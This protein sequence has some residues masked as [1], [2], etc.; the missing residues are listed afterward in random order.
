MRVQCLHPPKIFLPLDFAIDPNAVKTAR[1]EK[2]IDPLAIGHWRVGGQAAGLVPALVRELLAQVLH[3]KDL[4]GSP[5]HGE[6][7]ELMPMRHRHIVVGSRG[8]VID[9]LLRVPYRDGRGNEDSISKD[10]W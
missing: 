9:R 5:A 10:N 8:V 6:E 1:T 3:P 4:A 2:D 7:H